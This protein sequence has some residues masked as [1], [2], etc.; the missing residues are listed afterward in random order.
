MSNFNRWRVLACMRVLLWESSVSPFSL[1]SRR[2]CLI[3]LTMAAGLSPLSIPLGVVGG[4]LAFAVAHAVLRKQSFAEELK[5]RL[6]FYVPNDADAYY[7]LL[8]SIAIGQCSREMIARW[9]LWESRTL[10]RGIA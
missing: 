7:R 2:A 3:G 10:Q 9:I 4:V 5:T 6:L 1:A 8:A